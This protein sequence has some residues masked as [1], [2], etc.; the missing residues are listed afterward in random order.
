MS[1]RVMSQVWATSQH[2]GSALLMLLAIADHAHDDGG[3]AYPSVATLSEKTRMS[4]RQCRSLLRTLEK[5]GELIVERNTGP[6]GTNTYTVRT[7][8][9]VQ[10]S[11]LLTGAEVGAKQ[12]QTPLLPAAPKPGTEP[13]T[14]PSKVRAASRLPSVKDEIKATTLEAQSVWIKERKRHILK[15]GA[16]FARFTDR[17]ALANLRLSCE[18]ALLQGSWQD[19]ET[20]LRVN[21]S[22]P[23]SNPWYLDE[24][25]REQAGLRHEAETLARKMADRQKED[26]ELRREHQHRPMKSIAELIPAAIAD[27]RN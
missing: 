27:V 8:A 16:A 21:A 9:G 11:H 23:T 26:S 7:S 3:G 1:I 18:R 12:R 15:S 22:T 17:K 4:E 5:S 6:Q 20:A 19:I 24:W 13:G 25:T 2:K 10:T 14:E